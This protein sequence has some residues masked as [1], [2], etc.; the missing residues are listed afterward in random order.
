MLYAFHRFQKPHES[1]ERID[2]VDDCPGSS[3]CS[4]NLET[5]TVFHTAGNGRQWKD[6]SLQFLSPSCVLYQVYI[7]FLCVIGSDKGS[8]SG[9]DPDHKI[10]LEVWLGLGP[11]TLP[12]TRFWFDGTHVIRF[13]HQWEQVQWYLR[14]SNAILTEIQEYFLSKQCKKACMICKSFLMMKGTYLFKS[15][16]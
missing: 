5:R 1:S 15:R 7:H 2:W 3:F 8:W 13:V 14:N 11:E 12:S 10:G 4:L 6:F 9:D 16:E